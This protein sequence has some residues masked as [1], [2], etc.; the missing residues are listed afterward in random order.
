[1]TETAIL[2]ATT[3]LGK[4]KE[5]KIHLKNLPLRISSLQELHLSGHFPETGQT[6]LENARGKS[7]FY[8]RYWNELTLAEDSGLEIEYLQGAPGVYSSRF[9]GETASDEDNILKVLSLMDNTPPEARKARFVSC[10]VLSR[11]GRIIK[12]IEEEALGFITP[13]KKGQGGF[14][15]DPIFFYPPSGKTFAELSPEEKNAVSHR[16]RALKKLST[17]LHEYMN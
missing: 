12:E 2:L 7:L 9:A 6:F 8:S 11:K 17:F 15:Y 10:I 13:Q 1:M 16:G 14:G 3:N 5:F 4:I